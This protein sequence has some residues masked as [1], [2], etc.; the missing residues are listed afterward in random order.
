MKMNLVMK[1]DLQW[2]T[3]NDKTVSERPITLL[4]CGKVHIA[5]IVFEERS[6]NGAPDRYTVQFKIGAIRS[7]KGQWYL[8][9]S[10]AQEEVEKVAY[11]WLSYLDIRIVPEVSDE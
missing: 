11:H 4:Y 6:S 9:L 7:P 5:T 10:S 8:S 2:V 3:K 1:Y